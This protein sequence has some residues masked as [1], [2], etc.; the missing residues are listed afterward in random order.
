MTRST[1]SQL[2]LQRKKNKESEHAT[3]S[4]IANRFCPGRHGFDVWLCQFHATDRI[5]SDDYG[6]RLDYERKLVTV[7]RTQLLDATM[8]DCRVV[9]SRRTW[10]ED[11]WSTKGWADQMQAPKRVMNDAGTR[12]I[13][14]EGKLD[15]HFRFSDAYSRVA[16]DILARQGTY[17]G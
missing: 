4:F 16:M 2:T 15:D 1:P 8:D 9:P 3:S 6:M 12:F 11:V 10:P 7:D 17:H 5:G 13:W 14:T